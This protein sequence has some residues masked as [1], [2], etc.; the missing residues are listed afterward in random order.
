MPQ[1]YPCVVILRVN[2]LVA[3]FERGGHLSLH[4]RRIGWNDSRWS[5]DLDEIVRVSGADGLK[6]LRELGGLLLRSQTT[7]G[8]QPMSIT[9]LYLGPVILQFQEIHASLQAAQGDK[10]A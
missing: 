2:L 7:A 4:V 1:K 10:K 5:I 3:C 8:E 9:I 6:L